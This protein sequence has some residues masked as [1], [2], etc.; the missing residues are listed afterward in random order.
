MKARLEA[1]HIC[2]EI[3]RE[4]QAIL[5]AE[6]DPVYLLENVP[7]SEA[8]GEPWVLKLEMVMHNA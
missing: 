7:V 1:Y 4:I 8:N 6:A 3:Y 2:E 5:A